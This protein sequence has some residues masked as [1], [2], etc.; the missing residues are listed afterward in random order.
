MNGLAVKRAYVRI[1]PERAAMRL[2]AL[3]LLSALLYW[4]A[5]VRPYSLVALLPQPHLA[6]SHLSPDPRTGL[7]Y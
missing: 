1:W 5:F 4:A 7:A 6:I 3:G 2:A